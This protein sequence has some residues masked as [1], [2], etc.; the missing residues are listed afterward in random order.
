[1]YGPIRSIWGK[2]NAAEKVWELTSR[3]CAESQDTLNTSNCSI[4]Q[5][6]LID[7]SIDLITPMVTQLTYEGLIDELFGINNTTAQLPSER[8]QSKD[9]QKE[10]EGPKQIILNSSDE[11]YADLRDKNFNAVGATLSKQ[12]S[13]I[14]NQFDERL[15][16]KTVQEMKQYVAKL[17]NLLASKHALSIHTNIAE[18]IKEVTCTDAFLDKL[19]VSIIT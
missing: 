3:L 2:G 11:L 1:M 14:S 15:G 16:D 4:D 12:A 5:L 10:N 8:F 13:K 6:I 18:C 19:H 17:P 9:D 7:R